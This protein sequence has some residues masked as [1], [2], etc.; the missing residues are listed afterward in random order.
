[1]YINYDLSIIIPHYNSF[2]K[3]NVLLQSIPENNSIEIIVVDDYSTNLSNDELDSL[4]N[5]TRLI[6]LKNNQ[7][8][9][10]G[11]ARNIG[12]NKASKK[13]VLFADSDDY[14]VKKNFQKA[15]VAAQK[16]NK[17][18]VFFP[19]ISYVE[20]TEMPTK[21]AKPFK[22][23]VLKYIHKQSAK[24][25][26]RLRTKFHVPWSKL[27]KRNYLIKNKI[28]FQNTIVSNDAL[29][30]L[31][32]GLLAKNIGA[33]DVVIYVYVSGEKSLTTIKDKHILQIRTDVYLDY[34]K[35]LK[36]NLPKKQ[37]NYHRLL[38]LKYIY[39]GLKSGQSVLKS[40]NILKKNKIKIIF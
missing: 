2:D 22:T 8:K 40:I 25:E 32:S 15:I 16:L 37:M 29:F 9:G 21:K 24:N 12:L 3:L 31:K 23:R 19:P 10:A 6:F 34:I 4:S 7:T 27:Y 30:S 28:L 11:V 18:I 39:M 36:N 1:M 35:Y 38:G 13:Y 5:N 14:F 20:N 33:L 26:N 17:D